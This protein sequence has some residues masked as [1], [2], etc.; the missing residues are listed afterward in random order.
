MKSTKAVGLKQATVAA[1]INSLERDEPRTAKQLEARLAGVHPRAICNALLGLLERPGI[2]KTTSSWISPSLAALGCEFLDLN[3]ARRIA[4]NT[5]IGI[6]ARALA[7]EAMDA[8]NA[9]KDGPGEDEKLEVWLHW[10]ASCYHSRKGAER[11]LDLAP[12]RLVPILLATDVGPRGSTATGQEFVRVCFETADPSIRKE[13]WTDFESVR[14][15]ARVAARTAYA[16]LSRRPALLGDEQPELLATI[17]REGRP[18]DQHAP[19]GRKAARLALI[20]PLKT[21]AVE[22]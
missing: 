6:L 17:L 4:R 1:L 11:E 7:L 14:E 18:S 13:L 5:R 16:A 19:V 3:R 9:F 22:L 2:K 8:A 12:L 15:R 10:A 20:H 21:E